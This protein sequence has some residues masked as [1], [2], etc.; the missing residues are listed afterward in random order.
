MNGNG[1]KVRTWQDLAAV[2]TSAALGGGLALGVLMW[3]MKLDDRTDDLQ[4]DIGRL[5]MRISVLEH[6]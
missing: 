6:E 1:F 4:K 2:M 5:E 3:G